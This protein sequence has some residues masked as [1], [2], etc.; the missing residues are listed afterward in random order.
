MDGTG[1]R[2]AGPAPG[3]PIGRGLS[4]LLMA[5]SIVVLA[6]GL[7]AV[8]DIVVNLLAAAF[9]SMIAVPLLVLLQRTLRIPRW[10]SLLLVVT[11][12]I[13]AVMGLGY[14]LAQ[15]IANVKPMLPLYQARFEDLTRELVAALHVRGLQVTPDEVVERLQDWRITDYAKEI[16]LAAASG[17]QSSVLVLLVTAFILAEASTLPEKIRLA[18]PGMASQAGFGSVA[19]KVRAYLAVVTQLNILMGFATYIACVIMGIEFA[20]LLAFLVFFLN[21]IPTI[22]A[23]VGGAIPVLFAL[24]APGQGWGS[25]IA[26]AIVQVVLGV[27]VGSVIQPRL[28]GAR[29]GLSP[30]VVLLSLVVWGYLLGV[31]GMF[32]AVPLTIIVKIVLDSTDDLRWLGILLGDGRVAARAGQL[33]PPPTSAPGGP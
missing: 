18:F 11:L 29:L 23:I 3:A 28:L 14:L 12:T 15:S 32:F 13:A 20:P 2:I 27:V 6:A 19:D 10:L 25:A 21:Y 33:P 17:L 26:M 31:I 9:I 8:Q 5:A 4:I 22:G 16:L 30:L 7:R 24:V 1:T